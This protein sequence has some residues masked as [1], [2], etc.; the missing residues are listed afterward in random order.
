MLC[1]SRATTDGLNKRSLTSE[2]FYL[3]RNIF[4]LLYFKRFNI[5]YQ[6]TDRQTMCRPGVDFTNILRKA[7]THADPENEKKRQ[8]SCQSFLR[9]QGL[10]TQK[11]Q[12]EC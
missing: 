10:R 9:F 4:F 6:A 11:L 2:N 1:S 5:Y 7:F 3:T 12:V 8:S